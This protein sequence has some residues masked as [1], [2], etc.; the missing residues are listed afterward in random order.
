MFSPRALRRQRAFFLPAFC[1]PGSGAHACTISRMW[2]SLDN[3][4]CELGE[5]PFWHPQERSL[6]WL[7]IPGRAVLR[8][9]GD[10]GT[11]AATVQRWPLVHRARLHG[12]G[13][14]AAAS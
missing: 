8:T 2:T 12:P 9:R 5:S 6:Y 7:D 4:L 11:P 13:P 10:I 1:L 3:S 14:R